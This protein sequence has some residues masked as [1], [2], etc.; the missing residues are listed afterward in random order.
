MSDK[1]ENFIGIGGANYG[2]VKCEFLF[3]VPICGRVNGFYPGN[4]TVTPV[5][6]L[7]SYLNDLDVNGGSEAENVVTFF[8]FPFDSVIGV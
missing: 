2:M 7:S 4:L 3:L 6:G 8:T 5:K 1:V